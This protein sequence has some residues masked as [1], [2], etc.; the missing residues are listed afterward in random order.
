MAKIGQLIKIAKE[1]EWPVGL[2]MPQR[3]NFSKT[4]KLAKIAKRTKTAKNKMAKTA[5]FIKLVEVA[6][7]P[8][9][10]EWLK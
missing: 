3:P 8:K 1:A 10:V 2:K 5:K 6:E 4:T 7:K 9:T